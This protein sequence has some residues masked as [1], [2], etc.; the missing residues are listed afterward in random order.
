MPIKLCD[1]GGVTPLKPANAE[2]GV[3]VIQLPVHINRVVLQGDPC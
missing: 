1:P 2:V 3:S